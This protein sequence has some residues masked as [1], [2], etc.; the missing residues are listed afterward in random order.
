MKHKY[1]FFSYIGVFLLTVF[2]MFIGIVYLN[3]GHFTYTLDDAYI[4]LALAE[5]IQ[6][7]HYGINLNEMSAP[8]SSILWP[9]LLSVFSV[10]TLYEYVPL[11]LN[12]ICAISS[13]YVLYN[14]IVMSTED[15]TYRYALVKY[16]IPLFVLSANTFGLI[17]CGMEHSLQVLSIVSIA[18][19]LIRIEK[20]LHVPAILCVVI[21]LVAAV[22]RYENFAVIVPAI[23]YIY[24]KKKTSLALLLSGTVIIPV[25]GFSLFLLSNEMEFLPSSILV[26]SKQIF[27]FNL[28]LNFLTKWIVNLIYPRGLLMIALM[29]ICFYLRKKQI[30]SPLLNVLI[31]AIVL[32]WFAGSYGVFVY[33]RY[34]PYIISFALLLCV[35]VFSGLLKDNLDTITTYKKR[36]VICVMLIN[37]DI[38]VITLTIPFAGNNIYQQHYHIH[39]FVNE[40]YKKPVAVNDLG[41]VSFNNDRY[42]LDL[43]GLGNYDSLN[44]R[45][46]FS[47]KSKKTLLAANKSYHGEHDWMSLNM[48]R[49]DVDLAIIYEHWFKIPENWKKVAELSFSS[50]KVTAASNTVSFYISSSQPEEEIRLSLSKFK[51]SLKGKKDMTLQMY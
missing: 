12:V 50:L 8:S 5:N 48:D 39:K 46:I 20:K 36:I 51:K 7:G 13:L 26:K 43:Y 47:D 28:S 10:F 29:C 49:Y 23:I 17:F 32:Q 9:F 1:L 2:F 27:P 42:V 21:F 38:L 6:K 30:V 35:Y 18:W 34:S 14:V 22:T 37:L 16:C 25:L 45:L 11:F 24:T 41:Y 15:E 33:C 4:H 40:F 31:T 44:N 3:N 19:C